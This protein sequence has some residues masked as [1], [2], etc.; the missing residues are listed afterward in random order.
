MAARLADASGAV[1][2]SVCY[3]LALENRFPAALDDAYTVLAWAVDNAA[4]VS[5]RQNAELGAALRRALTD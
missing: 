3:R 2:I 5:Q 4:E 1:V